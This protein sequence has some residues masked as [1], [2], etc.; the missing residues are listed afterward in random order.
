MNLFACVCLSV[1]L[2]LCEC[3]SE[4]VCLC[5]SLS[6]YLC[7]SV[8]L[9]V[10]VCTNWNVAMVLSNSPVVCGREDAE[11]VEIP[12]KV[13]SK[14]RQLFQGFFRKKMISGPTECI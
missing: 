6:V 7:V 3:V 13:L 4:C 5:V 2:S 12:E 11:T 14:V 10:G 9:C 8:C 1:C